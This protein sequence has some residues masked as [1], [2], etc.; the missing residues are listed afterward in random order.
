MFSES[1]GEKGRAESHTPIV[2]KFDRVSVRIQ[3][4][5]ERF[6]KIVLEDKSSTLAQDQWTH[7]EKRLNKDPQIK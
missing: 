4:L 7:I 6:Q 2:L 1:E 3:K 5:I